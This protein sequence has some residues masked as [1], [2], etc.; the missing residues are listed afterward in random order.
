[1]NGISCGYIL[2]PKKK[3]EGVKGLCKEIFFSKNPRFLWTWVGGSRSHSDLFVGKS[4]QNSPKPVVIFWI[5]PV[6]A[7]LKVVSYL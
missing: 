2:V 3:S 5:L 6:Y 1:M 7:L 4:S